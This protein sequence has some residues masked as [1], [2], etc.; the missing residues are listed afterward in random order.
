MRVRRIARPPGGPDR[1]LLPGARPSIPRVLE[2]GVPAQREGFTL[3]LR[4]AL[5]RETP[6]PD[7]SR[8]VFSAIVS[9]VPDT[10]ENGDSARSAGELL[11]IE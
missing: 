8:G 11:A 2:V 4:H 10:R 3:L 1:R 5:S 6:T 9:G 7:L